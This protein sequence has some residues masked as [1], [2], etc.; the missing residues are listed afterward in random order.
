VNGNLFTEKIPGDFFSLGPAIGLAAEYINMI[1][2]AASEKC[3][4]FEVISCDSLWIA[5]IH[6]KYSI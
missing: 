2:A 4:I 1:R 5:I 6:I 3:P